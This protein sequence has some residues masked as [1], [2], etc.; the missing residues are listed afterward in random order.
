MQEEQVV[1][2]DVPFYG[3]RLPWYGRLF[4]LYL[5]VLLIG[6]AVRAARMFWVLWKHRRARRE[7]RT[8]GSDEGA[9]REAC[10]AGI[11]S[12]RNWSHVTLLLAVLVLAADLGRYLDSMYSLKVSGVGALCGAI[13]YSL[14]PFSAGVIVCTVLFVMAMVFEWLVRRWVGGAGRG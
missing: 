3:G 10:A 2:I 9:F 11:L 7:G 5:L 1:N 8:Q 6:M 4:L 14:Q 13:A 12:F